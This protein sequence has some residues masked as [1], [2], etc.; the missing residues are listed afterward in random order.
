[1]KKLKWY[2]LSV[3]IIAGG[4]VGLG[5]DV[6]SQMNSWQSGLN[7]N[8]IIQIQNQGG[9]REAAGSVE[10]SFYSN[11]SFGVTSPR[12]ISMIVDPWRNDPSGAWGLWYRMDF[13]KAEVDIGLST[14]AHFDHDALDRL[15]ANML[16]DRM[17]GTFELGDVKI[18]GIADKHQCVAPGIVAWTEAVKQFEGRNDPCP[19]TNFRH[20][21]NSIYLIETGGLR[22]LMWG[23]N[24]PTPP[25]EVLDKI[26]EVDVIFVP[27]DGSKHILDYAQADSVVEMTG[28]K[29]AI[30]HHYLV[31]ETT[32]YT[33]T[34]QDA[35]EWTQSHSHTMLDG[36]TIQIS[37]AD[38]ADMKGHVM[39]FG[40]NHLAG[41]GNG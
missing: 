6:I 1:M 39:Y 22:L 18:T 14:H 19:P 35:V 33:S 24:R 40:S 41:D 26:G 4:L 8:R 12:G 10:I 23:D 2:A 34:L 25:Q 11:S 27:V 29:V 36:P 13:P 5:E 30:P 3:A 15:D 16:L 31:P 28:A 32:F 20:M 37:A 9:T 38:I 7:H 21:D 17:G